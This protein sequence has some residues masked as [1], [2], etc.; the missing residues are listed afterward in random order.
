MATMQAGV[1]PSDSPTAGSLSGVPETLLIPL[2]MRAAE[3]RR[4]DAIIRDE[5]AVEIIASLDYDFAHLE[6]VWMTQIDIAVRTEI[7]DEAARRFVERDPQ[8][9]VVNLGAGL[10]GRFYRLDNGMLRWFDLDLPEVIQ[11]RRRFYREEDR[12]RFLAKSLLDFSWIDEL[13]RRAGEPVLI[14]AE[15]V[16]HYFEEND[17]RRLFCEIADRL[18]GAELLFHST[19]PHC[20]YH[21][22]RSRLFRSFAARFRWGIWSGRKIEPWDSRF[23]FLDEWA[24]VDRHRRRWGW[25]RFATYV[26]W[27]R[28]EF[29]SAMKITHLRFREASCP[30][31]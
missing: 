23:E 24:F 30:S 19:S 12:H 29:R 15:G 16:L 13:Q 17:V 5:K 3:T 10:D 14:I 18:P 28:R 4:P 27:V 1:A 7:L 9:L 6:K 11:L 26:P 21:Q 22:P 2:F 8:A 20:L 31:S 25:V